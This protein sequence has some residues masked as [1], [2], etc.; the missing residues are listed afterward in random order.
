[1]GEETGFEIKDR[2]FSAQTEGASPHQQH[3]P[4]EEKA[5]TP[6]STPPPTEKGQGHRSSPSHASLPVTFTSFIL[7]LAASGLVHLGHEADP[8]SGNRSVDLM[9]AR[10]TIDLLSLLQ[11]KTKGNLTSEEDAQLSQ[12]LFALRMMFVE[13]DKKR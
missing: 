3:G 11:E 1:M 8:A 9:M 4:V 6:S 2:R 13:V 12:T 10:Q 5:K 7:S